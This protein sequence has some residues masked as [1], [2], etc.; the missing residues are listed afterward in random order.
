MRRVF[1]VE[2]APGI[3]AQLLKTYVTV[4]V[5]NFTGFNWNSSQDYVDTNQNTW[6]CSNTT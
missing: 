6:T 1:E 3:K 4:L 5:L 2:K